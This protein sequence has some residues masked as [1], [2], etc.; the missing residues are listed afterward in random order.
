MS[1][2]EKARIK[3]TNITGTIV[4]IY[5]LKGEKIFILESDKENTPNGY[6][7]ENRLVDCLEKELEKL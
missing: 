3:G 2:F 6:G 4:D 7:P 1:E 5:M